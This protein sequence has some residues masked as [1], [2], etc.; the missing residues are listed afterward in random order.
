MNDRIGRDECDGKANG[1]SAFAVVADTGTFS[2][3]ERNRAAD[4]G[5]SVRQMDDP[6]GGVRSGTES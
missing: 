5:L 6:C 1:R 4:G 3:I 2:L